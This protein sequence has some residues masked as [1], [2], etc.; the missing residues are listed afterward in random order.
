MTDTDVRPQHAG[1]QQRQLEGLAAADDG[2]AGVGAAVVADD[3]IVLVGEQ[4]DDLALGLVAPLQADDTG[5]GGGHGFAPR[6]PGRGSFPGRHKKRLKPLKATG[7]HGVRVASNSRISTGRRGRRQ[8]PRAV[9]HPGEIVAHPP[10][11]AYTTFPVVPPAFELTRPQNRL[12]LGMCSSFRG[13]PAASCQPLPPNR[14]FVGSSRG[15]IARSD[16]CST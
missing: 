3:E 7:R 14:L 15:P 1:R 11:P 16:S 13:A 4:I 5:A 12:A 9:A 8:G 10:E 6:R 2:V